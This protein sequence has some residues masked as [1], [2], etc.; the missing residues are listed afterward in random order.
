MDKNLFLKYKL[1][2]SIKVK[3]KK[4]SDGIIYAKFPEYPGCMTLAKN[5]I[6]LIQNV[7]DAILT[8]FEV[9]RNEAKECKILYIPSYLQK[10]IDL[11]TEPA[12]NKKITK[13]EEQSASFLL[14]G[15]KNNYGQHTDIR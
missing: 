15:L 7:T 9:P 4:N 14:Y 12:M 8:Y 5:E 3:Y 10:L 11:H 2:N 13:R 6:E 1:P